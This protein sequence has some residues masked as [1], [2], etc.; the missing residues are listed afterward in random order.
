M[1]PDYSAKSDECSRLAAKVTRLDNRLRF[2]RAVIDGSLVLHQFTEQELVLKLKQSGFWEEDGSNN[3]DIAGPRL[4]VD[5][6]ALTERSAGGY[7]Y[8][9]SVPVAC[10]TTD[11][12]QKLESHCREAT[13]AYRVAVKLAAAAAR[14][15]IKRKLELLRAEKEGL[16]NIS[17]QV[18]RSNEDV[19]SR[20]E[21]FKERISEK[22][23]ALGDAYRAKESQLLDQVQR[24][25][26]TKQNQLAEQMQDVQQM[27]ASLTS[28][29]AGLDDTLACQDPYGFL[30]SAVGIQGQVETQLRVNLES[31]FRI[32]PELELQFDLI[33]EIHA[34]RS[35]TLFG[36]NQ[37]AMHPRRFSHPSEVSSMKDMMPSDYS[38]NR[39]D[40]G[41]IHKAAAQNRP[42][43]ASSV[44]KGDLSA[45]QPGS[46]RRFGPPSTTQE[47]IHVISSGT[48][49]E[50]C[51][52][53]I[54][55][56]M[57][58]NEAEQTV[59]PQPSLIGT[60]R[61]SRTTG[62]RGRQSATDD[63]D[64]ED[65]SSTSSIHSHWSGTSGWAGGDSDRSLLTSHRL[66]VRPLPS[67]R[68]RWSPPPSASPPVCISSS[69]RPVPYRFASWSHVRHVSES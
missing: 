5:K 67:A 44:L 56:T 27:Q 8:L 53:I 43:H 24:I 25:E 31:V 13:E 3:C 6:D 58:P 32:Q 52:S 51:A 23:V 7:G 20:I 33:P 9:L 50:E 45:A 22:L 30:E 49:G 28:C 68:R 46:R 62:L 64:H 26:Q 66:P 54:T 55:V 59:R 17:G 57:R 19:A 1:M 37:I 60:H 29:L 18:E 21:L 39:T 42:A 34:M 12:V 48:R 47:Q 4:V 10:F 40:A 16:V 11:A 35:L 36:D 63:Q 69:V 15:G 65:E 38:S 2:V 61:T 41:S 14:Q